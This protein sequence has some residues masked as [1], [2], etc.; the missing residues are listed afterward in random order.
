MPQVPVML[1]Q[2][3]KLQTLLDLDNVTFAVIP[4]GVELAI[5]P[6]FG[7]QIADGTVYVEDYLGSDEHRD[8]RD[9]GDV[10]PDL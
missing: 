8:E 6:F 9:G 1:G 7:F 3:S 10:Q 2:L 4:M 5:A